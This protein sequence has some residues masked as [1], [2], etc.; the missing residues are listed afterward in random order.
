MIKFYPQICVANFGFVFHMEMV[1]VRYKLDC[2]FVLKV[3]YIIPHFR[4]VD[5]KFEIMIS[6]KLKK[7]KTSELLV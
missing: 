6:S 2:N 1:I 7:G 4:K 5:D 3:F